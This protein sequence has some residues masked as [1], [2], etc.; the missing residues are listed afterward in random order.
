MSGPNEQRHVRIV[1]RQVVEAGREVLA[2]KMIALGLGSQPRFA[3]IHPCSEP[4]TEHTQRFGHSFHH[5]AYDS[6][7]RHA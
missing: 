2:D 5:P 1:A 3:R 6:H 4:W 7:A